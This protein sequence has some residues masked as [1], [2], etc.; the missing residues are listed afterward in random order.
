MK[1]WW[2]AILVLISLGINHKISHDI[3]WQKAADAQYH[4]DIENIKYV[5]WGSYKGKSNY[6]AYLEGGYYY[7]KGISKIVKLSKY[8]ELQE[9]YYRGK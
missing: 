5:Y 1:Y 7:P 3:A 6:I 4:K 9:K 8:V 2:I